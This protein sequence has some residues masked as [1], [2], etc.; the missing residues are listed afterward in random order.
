[1]VSKLEGER[2]R[3]STRPG[4]TGLEL[5]FWNSGCQSLVH[6]QNSR[7][8]QKHY[9]VKLPKSAGARHYCPKIPR[10]PGTLGTRANSSPGLDLHWEKT[11]WADHETPQSLPL[12]LVLKDR[13]FYQMASLLF[14]VVFLPSNGILLRAIDTIQI[15]C[16][17]SFYQIY[18]TLENIIS[19]KI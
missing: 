5:G 13:T 18:L 4:Y 11:I 16:T 3:I 15:N 6:P 7:V 12:C 8:Q 2:N 9:L 19:P 1:M 14:S 10:V 17:Y